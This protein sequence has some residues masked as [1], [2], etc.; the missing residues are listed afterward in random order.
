LQGIFIDKKNKA[1]ML[2]TLVTIKVFVPRL[3]DENIKYG[4]LDLLLKRPLEK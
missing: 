1:P 4:D 3:A 2:T